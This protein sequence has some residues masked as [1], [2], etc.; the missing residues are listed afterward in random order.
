MISS[1]KLR[2][3]CTRDLRTRTTGR[4]GYLKV[5]RRFEDGMSNIGIRVRT[6]LVRQKVLKL[7]Y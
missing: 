5:E 4:Y 3:V 6:T 7:L 1:S 2:M